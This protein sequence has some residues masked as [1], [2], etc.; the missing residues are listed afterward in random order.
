MGWSVMKSTA[1]PG[2]TMNYLSLTDRN[3]VENGVFPGGITAYNGCNIYEGKDY[4]YTTARFD[5]V[6]FRKQW[7]ILADDEYD[8]DLDVFKIGELTASRGKR[9][10]VYCYFGYRVQIEFFRENAIADFTDALE[11]GARLLDATE[12]FIALYSRRYDT[13]RLNEFLINIKPYVEENTVPART[14]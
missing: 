1:A 4:S 3:C 2:S 7:R 6:P 8:A 5:G 12:K 10:E 13:R 11:E 14:V 9:I